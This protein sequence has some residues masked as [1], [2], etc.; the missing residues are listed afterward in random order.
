M[1][2]EKAFWQ[3]AEVDA[4]HELEITKRIFEKNKIL[5]ANDLIVNEEIEKLVILSKKITSCE[6]R[7][8]MLHEKS[9]YKES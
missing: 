2:D 1:I 4:L 3:A 6:M 9:E 7:T 8:K 5:I